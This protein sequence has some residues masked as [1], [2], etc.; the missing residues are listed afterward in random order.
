MRP[1]CAMIAAVPGF[2]A[3][4]A[5]KAASACSK[6]LQ[7][8]ADQALAEHRLH[9][10]WVERERA[11]EAL[12]GLVVPLRQQLR[13]AAIAIGV[14]MIRLGGDGPLMRLQRLGEQVH[15]HQRV[16][17][18]GP[19]HREIRLQRDRPLLDF[20]RLLET[21]L[22]EQHEAEIGERLGMA[23]LGGDRLRQRLL[24]EI[25]PAGVERGDA[26]QMQRVEMIR[27]QRDDLAAD[28]LRLGMPAGAIG[29]DRIGQQ[30]IRL[31]AALLLQP[32]VLERAR[33]DIAQGQL[34]GKHIP[35]ESSMARL[36][37]EVVAGRPTRADNRPRC[38]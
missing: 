29:R 31:L 18:A 34:S 30:R 32:C 21:F 6:C 10:A 16:A 17:E 8:D 15:V 11:L 33:T 38:G 35:G 9:M 12:I 25:Q 28:R 24:G 23:R 26:E 13:H 37:R 27:H 4:A 7:I 5:S 2:S 20:A 1:R 22:V 3:S 14:G 19:R 36:I